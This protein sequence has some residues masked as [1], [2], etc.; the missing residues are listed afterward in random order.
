MDLDG[1]ATVFASA[2]ADGRSSLYEHEC[3][4][5]LSRTG[6]EA[7]PVHRLILTG[8]RPGAADLAGIPGDRVVLK[9]VC[10]DIIHKTAAW[11]VR[12]GTKE[13]DGVE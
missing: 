10:P 7:A 13:A 8:Q 4:E 6:A 9:V 1:I 12:I 2:D 5:L 3:Y 11:A